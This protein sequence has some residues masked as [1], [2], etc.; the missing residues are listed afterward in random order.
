MVNWKI[1]IKQNIE[2]KEKHVNGLDDVKTKARCRYAFDEIS[3][4]WRVYSLGS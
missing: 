3:C 1:L 2:M 4:Y